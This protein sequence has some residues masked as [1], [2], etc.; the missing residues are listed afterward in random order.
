[1]FCAISS[2]YAILMRLLRSGRETPLKVDDAADDAIMPLSHTRFDILYR[3]GA[4]HTC[5]A[6]SFKHGR[7]AV[8]NFN[9][10]MA[11]YGR[12][13]R[14]ASSGFTAPMRNIMMCHEARAMRQSELY[15][16]A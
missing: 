1:M 6:R 8:A 13:I 3:S 9:I 12:I 14:S 4:W 10:F 11:S 16:F 7:S 5:L 2:K 15:C